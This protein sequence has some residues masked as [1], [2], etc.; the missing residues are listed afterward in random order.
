[1]RPLHPAAPPPHRTIPHRTHRHRAHRH[2]PVRHR[3]IP[4]PRL[5]EAT[6]SRTRTSLLHVPAPGRPGTGSRS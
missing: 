2:P 6:H 1:T 3:T 5:R 4:R